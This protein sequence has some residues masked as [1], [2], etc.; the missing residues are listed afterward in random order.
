ML[1]MCKFTDTMSYV[2]RR[3]DRSSL[4]ILEERLDLITK[5]ISGM[6]LE[7]F[8]ERAGQAHEAANSSDIQGIESFSGESN[9]TVACRV[10]SVNSQGAHLTAFGTRGRKS[11]D[12]RTLW[13][14]SYVA[15]YV[16]ASL[17]VDS[18]SKMN[19][20]SEIRDFDE[21]H[22]QDQREDETSY[23]VTPANWL[24]R[25]GFRR[26]LR[27]N[28]VSSS[29]RGWTATLEPVRSVPDDALIFDLCEDGDMIGVKRL[30]S[31]GHASVRDTDSRGYMPLHVSLWHHRDR[32]T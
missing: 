2:D 17:R 8:P 11:S 23:T 32:T 4:N 31:K 15:D 18:T 13:K 25:L 12:L 30:L 5:S 1:A 10:H 9:S 6:S 21:Q 14:E 27:L 3:S 16:L 26:G 22:H 28:L 24:L 29:T 7:H 19:I 20:I